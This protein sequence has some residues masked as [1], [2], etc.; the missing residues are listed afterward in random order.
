MWPAIGPRSGR[1]K[2]TSFLHRFG[3]AF[4]E[5]RP[6]GDDPIN[7]GALVRLANNNLVE[8]VVGIS[9]RQVNIHLAL[10]PSHR[11]QGNSFQNFLNYP[12]TGKARH[13]I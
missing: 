2:A 9:D 10:F 13:L 12:L 8:P 3:E 4:A 11:L 1:I 6:E 5:V 7:R